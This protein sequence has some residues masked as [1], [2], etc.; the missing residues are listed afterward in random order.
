MVTSGIINSGTSFRQKYGVFTAKI[1]L[2]DPNAKCAFW[3]LADKITPHVDICRTT[4]GKVWFDLFAGD[5]KSVKSSVGSRYANDYFIFT[6][7]W[8]ADKLVWKINGVDAF[9]QTENVPQQP[10]Y[11]NLAGGL[12]KP[13]NGSTTMEID[14]IRVY[15]VKN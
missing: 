8:T 10:M 13:I 1:K 11:I 7:I 6:L 12:D 9:Q 4:K 5:G 3:L 15:Q 14:W 2:G